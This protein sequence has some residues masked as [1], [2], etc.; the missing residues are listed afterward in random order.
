[1]HPALR[2]TLRGVAALVLLSV[3]LR[4]GGGPVAGLL[5]PEGG[6]PDRPAASPRADRGQLRTAVDAV[7]HGWGG[8]PSLDGAI[9]LPRGR[10]PHDL[11]GALRALPALDGLQVY[12][13]PAGPLRSVLRIYDGAELWLRAEVRPW[14]AERPLPA[15]VGSTTLAFVVMAPGGA[16]DLGSILKWKTPLGVALLP[17][18]PQTPRLAQAATRAHK[19]VL[20]VLDAGAGPLPLQVSAVPEAGGVV[21]VDDLPRA[22]LPEVFAAVERS[23]RY[24]IDART[25]P[26]TLDVPAGVPVRRAVRLAESGGPALLRNLAREEGQALAISDLSE[27]SA[28]EAFVSTAREDGH[29]LR[30]P[31]EVAMPARALAQARP[32][33]NELGNSP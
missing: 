18:D 27:E 1:M 20:I 23:G 21:L 5:F 33:P 29:T 32:V 25:A 31:N 24:V 28:L 15:T 9:S 2:S 11:E 10:S 6:P 16:A 14:L 22:A 7:V 19:D 12:V 8:A 26:E 13:R 4:W 30:F 17:F 3:A